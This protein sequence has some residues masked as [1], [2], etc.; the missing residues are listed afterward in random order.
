[1][2]PPPS[3][4][5]ALTITDDAR[6]MMRWWWFGPSMTCG[7]ATRQLELMRVAGVGGVEVAYIYPVCVDGEI[8]SVVN[9]QFLSP[10]FC[11]VLGFAAQ[12]AER[13]G[14]RFD[15]TLGSG[16]PFG[17]PHISPRHAAKQL[18]TVL[19]DIPAGVTDL[20]VPVLS[21]EGQIV[22]V[23]D[24][25]GQPL[26]MVN[27][28]LQLSAPGDESSQAT[29]LVSGPTGQV[30]KRACL[31]AEGL[32]LDHYDEAA[33]QIH[34]EAVGRHL[35]D[36]AGAGRV[37][38]VFTDSLE[39][40]GS[41]WTGSFLSEFEGRR[42]YDLTPFLPMLV[43]G[44]RPDDSAWRGDPIDPHREQLLRDVQHDYAQ[45]LTDL[46]HERFLRPLQRFARK[47]DVLSRVQAYGVPPATM[48]SYRYVDLPEGECTLGASEIHQPA[49]WTEITPN[50]I[51]SS[52]SR[53]KSHQM[54]S[55][56]TWTRL[57]SPPYAATPL[58][59]KAE[60]DQ[61]FLQGVNQIMG[62]GWCHRPAGGDP[63]QWVFYAAGNFNEANPWHP[64]MPDLSRYLQTV[65]SLLRTGEPIVDVAIYLPDHDVWSRQSISPAK[66]NLHHVNALREHIGLRLPKEL[67]RLGFNFDLIDD[68]SIEAGIK[69][70]TEGP[71]YRMI[72]LPDVERIPL[73]TLKGLQRLSEDGVAIVAVGQLPSQP[74]GHA[75]RAREESEIRDATQEL[76]H[77]RRYPNIHWLEAWDAAALRSISVPDV[78][79][80]SRPAA[81]GY[82]H[83]RMGEADLYFFVN[84]TNQPVHVPLRFRDLRPHRYQL[85]PMT[86]IARA[87]ASTGLSLEAYQSLVCVHSDRALS[88]AEFGDFRL[89]S[90]AIES[91][92]DQ[93]DISDDWRLI[94]PDLLPVPL[95]RL[96]AWTDQPSF[97][98]YAGQGTYC[99]DFLLPKGW[100]RRHVEL[101][102]DTPSPIAPVRSDPSQRNTGFSTFLDPPIQDAAEVFLNG[103]RVTS[104]FCPPYRVNLTDHMESGLNRLEVRIYSRLINALI[105]GGRFDFAHVHQRYGQRFDGIQD[106]GNT[107]RVSAGMRGSV[108]LQAR[109]PRD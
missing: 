50:R 15:L 41:N 8:E 97:R 70:R 65:S 81:V 66:E 19:V 77:S 106:V 32:V 7:E 58:D 44:A 37:R 67:L 35:I 33:L 76:F 39:V 103:N 86:R 28:R 104:L 21:G 90:T 45:T 68:S 4:T 48:S 13:L 17:G 69:A 24:Q 16:W 57:H 78:D 61:F 75:R 82:V 1:M 54:V 62:H 31:G 55:A 51:A 91:V 85:D 92:L 88:D 38:A 87:S 94:I 107:S 12:E 6:I 59:M 46:L 47:H 30:V 63:S 73:A 101:V 89:R 80:A 26:Q 52:A 79:L 98:C 9:Q 23:M 3:I 34:L 84:T 93:L 100:H 43:A 29:F 72:I 20:P 49:E 64:V 53:Y 108:V 42:G 83:R 102:F 14:M 22:S 74:T 18:K 5:H 36:A 10:E 2:T 11:E 56:E 25:S 71:Q 105:D 60:A 95:A 99:R 40:Y 27:G 96:S 109:I